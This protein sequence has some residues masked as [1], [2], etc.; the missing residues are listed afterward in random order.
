MEAPYE[1]GRL[2]VVARTGERHPALGDQEEFSGASRAVDLSAGGRACGAV[3]GARILEYAR[4]T[5]MRSGTRQ[6]HLCRGLPIL[7]PAPGDL[8]RLRRR[9]YEPVPRRDDREE[10]ALLPAGAGAPR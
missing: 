10:P 2:D 8:L 7:L 4:R 1:P 6:P 9:L 3:V 5:Q